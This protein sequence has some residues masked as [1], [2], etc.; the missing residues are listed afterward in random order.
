VTN[1]DRNELGLTPGEQTPG[2]SPIRVEI[3]SICSSVSDGPSASAASHSAMDAPLSPKKLM[4]F[5][6]HNAVPV[7]LFANTCRTSR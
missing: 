1:N 5:H 7:V 4:A 2:V 3:A 6:S